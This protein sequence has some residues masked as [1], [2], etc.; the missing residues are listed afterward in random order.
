M[1]RIFDFPPAGLLDAEPDELLALL[2]G[3]ALIELPGRQEAPL[4]V[5]V[6]LHGNE[7]T[8]WFA[9]R[10][11]LRKSRNRTLP[12]A[13]CLFI[14][15]VEAAARNLR[16]LD[17]Q[18]D[19]NRVW[20]GAE[21]SG[22][23]EHA[24][25]AEVTEHMRKRRVF[26]GIDVHNNT[27]LNP[28]YACINRREPD[29]FHLA[30]LFSRTVVYF[31]RPLG[32]QSL[33]FSKF[34]PS[35]TVEAGKPG[36]RAG[37]AHVLEFLESALRL[38]TFPQHSVPAHDMDLF[39]TMATV[40]IPETV[41]FRFASDQGRCGQDTDL[42]LDPELE[43]LNFREVGPGVSFGRTGAHTEWPLRAQAED[44]RDVTRDYFRIRG[45]DLQL[46]RPVMP[47]MLTLDE[48]AIRQ[49]CLCYLM[50][51]LHPN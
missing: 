25:M 6:L 40:T 19:Y 47:S 1:L 10:E 8:G 21:T 41:R 14:G 38:T 24:L 39:H 7:N 35:V 30:T 36:D 13:L 49:D 11:L 22:A 2:G 44:G 9:V 48:R 12:R 17:G 27:G 42:C 45:N 15:N 37:T 20:P 29:F 33:A 26:A 50:E 4:F 46:A 5:S 18:L 43:R 51:R 23:P 32:V 31:T 3:P 28:H 16:R 34:C